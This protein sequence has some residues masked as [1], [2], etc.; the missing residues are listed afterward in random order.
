MTPIHPTTVLVSHSK[1]IFCFTYPSKHTTCFLPLTKRIFMFRFTFLD[2]LSGTPIR[3][4][5]K[6][7]TYV[8]FP[9]TLY[10]LLYIS[11]TYTHHLNTIYIYISTDIIQHIN[12]VITMTLRFYVFI[13]RKKVKEKENEK[14]CNRNK[15]DTNELQGIKE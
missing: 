2:K 13:S 9:T 3:P 10:V 7:L 1:N 11:T 4:I 12:I 5:L 6:S 15:R 8:S 14:Y